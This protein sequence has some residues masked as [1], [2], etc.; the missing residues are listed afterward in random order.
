MAHRKSRITLP[1]MTPGSA[2]HIVV[3]HFGTRGARPKI[4]LQAAIH[5]NELPGAM[6]LHHLLP[7]LVQADRA[8]RIVGEVVVVPTVNPIGLSQLVG[9]QHLGRYD[10]LGRDNFNRNWPDLSDAVAERAGK[11]LRDDAATNAAAIRKAARAALEAMQ[12][13]NELQT[14]RVEIM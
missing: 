11:T 8:G 12:P 10:L 2:R 6:A 7:M 5:A 4:Y 9:S 14:L 3:H 1:S 13:M